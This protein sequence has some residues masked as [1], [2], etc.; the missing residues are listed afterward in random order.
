[1]VR[2]HNNT[3]DGN[4]DSERRHRSA[5]GRTPILVGLRFLSLKVK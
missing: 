2:R 4:D 1:V 5:S 3:H